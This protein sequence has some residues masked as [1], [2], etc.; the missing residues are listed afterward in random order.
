MVKLI[1]PGLD[2]ELETTLNLIL[3]LIESSKAQL[4]NE[5]RLRTTQSHLSFFTAVEFMGRKTTGYTPESRLSKLDWTGWLSV[6]G[7]RTCIG[8]AHVFPRFFVF[9]LRPWRSNRTPLKKST[10]FI[11]T[12]RWKFKNG[13]VGLAAH[14]IHRLD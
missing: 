2:A 1:R 14:L 13:L 4:S 5:A 8:L 3:E 12:D 11:C 10:H 6:L 7:V 9:C